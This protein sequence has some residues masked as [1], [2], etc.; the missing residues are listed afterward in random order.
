[1]NKLFFSI[2]TFAAICSTGQG[3]AAELGG[4]NISVR[5]G[6]SLANCIGYHPNCSSSVTLNA[7]GENEIIDVKQYKVT[8]FGDIKDDTKVDVE[9]PVEKNTQKIF[10]FK[11]TQGELAGKM[12]YFAFDNIPPRLGSIASGKVVVKMYSQ[13]ESQKANQW[14]DVGNITLDQAPT[15][16]KLTQPFT[17]K[18]DGTLVSYDPKRKVTIEYPLGKSKLA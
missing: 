11:P 7:V 16:E 17:I 12:I 4:T 9:I 14:T 13:N 10:S 2:I 6:L 1:M 15:G 8:S 18:P 5:A 3:F